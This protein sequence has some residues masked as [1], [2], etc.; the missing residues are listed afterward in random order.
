MDSQYRAFGECVKTVLSA[1][2]Q[3]NLDNISGTIPNL[4]FKAKFMHVLI[5][6]GGAVD[7]SLSFDVNP[8]TTYSLA[9]V[10]PGQQI[11][12]VKY[13]YCSSCTAEIFFFA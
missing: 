10:V 6:E 9:A 4:K 12:G 7:Y 3:I 8:G 5:L 1:G 13:I 11:V 2:M